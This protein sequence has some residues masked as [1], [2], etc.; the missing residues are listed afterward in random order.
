M[1]KS[2]FQNASQFVSYDKQATSEEIQAY[3]EHIDSLIYSVNV[4]Q[5]DIAHSTSLLACFMQNSF[6]IHA[7]E[8]DH[9]I[10]Y[11]HD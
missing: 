6:L 10:I 7:T 2:L 9:L 8:A 11:L 5:I 4:L 1:Y 3:Q